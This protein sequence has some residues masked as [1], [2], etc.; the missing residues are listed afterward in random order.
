MPGRVKSAPPPGYGPASESNLTAAVVNGTNGTNCLPAGT[1]V[2][3]FTDPPLSGI[4]VN[5][6]DGGSGRTSAAHLGGCRVSGQERPGPA[7]RDAPALVTNSI[8]N[9]VQKARKHVPP[10]L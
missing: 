1:G 8:T 4:Q 2:V 6:R 5:F 10:G 3:T 9:S 7:R